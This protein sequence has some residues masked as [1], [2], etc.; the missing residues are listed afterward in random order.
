[1]NQTKKQRYSQEGIGLVEIAIALV[2]IGILIGAVIQ[3]KHLI[4]QA[5]VNSIITEVQNTRLKVQRFKQKYGFLPGDFPFASRDIQSTL[6]N[7]SGSGQLNGNPFSP[8]SNAGRFWIH[9]N[10]AEGIPYT[11]ST[12]LN[13]GDG[14]TE[15]GLGGGYT[16]TH[17]PIDSMPGNWLVLGTK[18][19]S[20][21]EGVVLTPEQAQYID[22]K[23]D[24]G[25]PL[26]GNVRSLEAKHQ[27]NGKCI[28]DGK[29]NVSTS[30]KAC[31][32]YFNIDE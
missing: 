8:E 21:G 6:P 29:Y 4:D 25:S 18:D 12:Q 22:K 27:T 32:M 9:L 28:K 26:T 11:P 31:V 10:A 15:C 23:L 13:Y 19:E 14:L 24:N 1:M 2:V 16:V 30:E 17:C 20:L 5:R 7:G 3:G